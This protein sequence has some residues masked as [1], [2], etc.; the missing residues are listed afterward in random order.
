MMDDAPGNPAPPESEGPTREECVQAM[1]AHALGVTAS[2]LG[3]LIIWLMRGKVS[4]FVNHHAKEALNMQ[5]T[6]AA[7]LLACWN[8]APEEWFALLLSGYLMLNTIISIPAVIAGSQGRL[9]HYPL[10]V[11]L[12]V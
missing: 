9:Y 7:I 1:L 5:I 11:R 8:F 2:F 10:P 6:L 3:P 12:I 4:A